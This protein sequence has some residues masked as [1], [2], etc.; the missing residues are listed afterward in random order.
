MIQPRSLT[1]VL[2]HKA[3]PLLLAVL[4]VS[5]SACRL[6]PRHPPTFVDFQR[7]GPGMLEDVGKVQQHLALQE[8]AIFQ[9]TDLQR[10]QARRTGLIEARR[11]A[12][13]QQGDPPRGGDG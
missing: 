7:V 8:A 11:Q 6:S 5:M 2:R 10:I 4:A 3:A 13:S 9:P 1:S 12:P